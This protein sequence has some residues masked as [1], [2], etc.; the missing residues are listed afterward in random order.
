MVRSGGSSGG[1]ASH[2][3]VISIQGPNIG[4]VVAA[5][6]PSINSHAL[7]AAISSNSSL[8]P[9]EICPHNEPFIVAQQT[10]I[11]WPRLQAL[12]AAR[13]HD[14]VSI[15]IPV[16][17]LVELTRR[18]VE[19][20]TAKTAYPDY[21][22]I[23]VDNGSTPEA[24]EELRLMVADL[25]RT[26]L[27]QNV[28]NLMFAMGCNVGGASS[29]GEYILFL[30]NDIEVVSEHWLGDLVEPLRVDPSVGIVS[31]KLL[32]PDRTVQHAGVVFGETSLFPY[33]IYKGFPSEH[34]AV[35]RLRVFRAVTGACMAL[36]ASDFIK[37]RGFDPAFV[38]GSE[39]VDLCLR[40]EMSLHRCCLY[41]PSAQLIHHEGK[42]PG[43]GKF[44]IQNRGIFLERWRDRIVSDDRRYYD[45]DGVMLAGYDYLDG[46]RVPAEI[47]SVQPRLVVP[48]VEAHFSAPAK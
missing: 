34:P 4:E 27:L 2:G 48:T 45:A 46:H 22:I 18:C 38:N 33:H 7:A 17:N 44:I 20:I 16:I 21:E 19:T 15:V 26:R 39:D 42:S 40:M 23:L 24:A 14:R 12:A 8:S 29:T 36:R 30:N 11:D 6:L 37:L 3:E 31:G 35:N 41:V 28:C 25:P 1:E 43:R 9:S 47:R 13:K 5:D 32:Y 10:L